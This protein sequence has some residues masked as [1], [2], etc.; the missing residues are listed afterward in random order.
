MTNTSAIWRQAEHAYHLP[1]VIYLLDKSH[2]KRSVSSRKQNSRKCSGNCLQEKGPLAETRQDRKSNKTR[3]NNNTRGDRN[4]ESND[5]SPEIPDRKGT[6]DITCLPFGAPKRTSVLATICEKISR[7]DEK[8][9]CNSVQTPL[10]NST[11]ALHGTVHASMGPT[12][13]V[14]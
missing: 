2:T 6:L 14:K 8:A 1:T 13:H 4:G 12:R 3:W 9:R 11:E 10:I 7:T 5:D